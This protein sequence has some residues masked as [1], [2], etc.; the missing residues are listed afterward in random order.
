LKLLARQRKGE[1]LPIHELKTLN[2]D[3]SSVGGVTVSERLVDKLPT[4]DRV[5]QMRASE[6]PAVGLL[7]AW[8]TY[9]F[10][11]RF[12]KEC[13]SAMPR[14]YGLRNAQSLLRKP[15]FVE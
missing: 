1:H 8:K 5:L 15:R 6:G 4:K 11:A 2:R 9:R 10:A 7:E 12:V 14:K 3:L 13:A